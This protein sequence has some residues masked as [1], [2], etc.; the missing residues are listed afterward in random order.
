MIFNDF[1]NDLK[2]T[3]KKTFPILIKMGYFVIYC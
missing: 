2:V 1:G 3:A